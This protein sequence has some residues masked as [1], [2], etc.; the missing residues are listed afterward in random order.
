MANSSPAAPNTEQAIKTAV[1]AATLALRGTTTERMPFC[2]ITWYGAIDIDPKYATV[3]VVLGGD[4]ESLLPP[5]MGFR[6]GESDPVAW[7]GE[8]YRAAKLEEDVLKLL[9]KLRTVVTLEFEK[10]GWPGPIPWLGFEA[11]S[12]LA[13][14]GG[15]YS[16]FK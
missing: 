9:V 11:A 15:G 2:Y 12:R 6:A 10:A 1:D 8:T 3:W 14:S 13:A 16:Y 5:N 4:A 7:A